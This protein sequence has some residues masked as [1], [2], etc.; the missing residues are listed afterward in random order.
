M[1]VALRDLPA[2]GVLGIVRPS[3]SVVDVVARRPCS[4]GHDPSV[5]RRAR[6]PT[7]APSRKGRKQ[8]M[9]RL[10]AIPVLC[11]AL[12]LA[13]WLGPVSAAG[14]PGG[15][16]GTTFV[17][18]LGDRIRVV[19]APIACRVVRVRELGR[20]VA[21]DCRRSGPL[22]GTRR[23]ALDSARS[24]R[25]AVRAMPRWH[26]SSRSP[27]T[28]ASYGDADE[29]SPRPRRCSHPTG[30]AP[31]DAVL[32]QRG[33]TVGRDGNPARAHWSPSSAEPV[34]SGSPSRSSMRAAIR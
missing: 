30:E 14:G 31:A 26:G 33:P 7:P 12:A 5:A 10:V 3:S 16:S 9:S 8:R 27:S 6:T 20:R 17:A 34:S 19:D 29:S 22:R 1:I 2:D 25:R 21:L 24:S 15:S 32:P 18:Q 11:A 23:H 28:T 4:A 13:A